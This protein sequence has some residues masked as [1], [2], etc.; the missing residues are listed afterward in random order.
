VMVVVVGWYGGSG[1]GGKG[2][3]KWRCWWDSGGCG[4]GRVVL[5]GC[6]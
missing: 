3:R 1:C 2:K 6:C 4:G 5:V